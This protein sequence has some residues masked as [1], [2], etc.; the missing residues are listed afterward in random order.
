MALAS[1]G[2]RPSRAD[3]VGDPHM[4]LRFIGMSFF[5]PGVVSESLPKMW[6]APAGYG[7]L[8]AGILAIYCHRGDG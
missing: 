4:F 1:S 8:L 6:A 3:L 2:R 5:V 7:D